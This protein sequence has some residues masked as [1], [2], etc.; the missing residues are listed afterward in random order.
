[1]KLIY[2]EDELPQRSPEWLELRSKTIGGSQVGPILGLLLKYEKPETLWKR[3]TGRLKEKSMN[4]AMERGIA[5]EKDALKAAIREIGY[6]NPDVQPFF[7][8]H[9]EIEYASVS[10]DGVDIENKYIIELKCPSIWNFKSVCENG[11]PDYY[12]AQVQWQLL[13]AEATWGITKAYFC[14]YYPEGAYVIEPYEFK[15]TLKEI[16]IEEIDY[17][18]EFCKAMLTVIKRF[19]DYVTYD[20]F[21]PEEFYGLLKDFYAQTD[22][23]NR[24]RN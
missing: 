13:T 22:I 17:H 7:V 9:P 4:A 8:I 10:Y 6:K 5:L 16:Y 3:L 12:Y 11:I 23:I 19:H 14:S 1:M 18:P 20:F 2:T 15:E 21:D 24:N